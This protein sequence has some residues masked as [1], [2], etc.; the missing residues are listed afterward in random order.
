MNKKVYRNVNKKFDKKINKK[1]NKK[2]NQK[3][4]NQNV[5]KKV[6]QKVIKKVFSTSQFSIV[7]A[8]SSLQSKRSPQEVQLLSIHKVSEPEK[9]FNKRMIIQYWSLKSI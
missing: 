2:V 1:V 7:C 6:N 8:S 9:L 4:I 3:N 5:I